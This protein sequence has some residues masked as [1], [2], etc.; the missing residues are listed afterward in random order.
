MNKP[1]CRRALCGIE[2]QCVLYELEDGTTAMV[3]VGAC[4]D[5]EVEFR[6]APASFFKMMVGQPFV[7]ATELKKDTILE[8]Q[9]IIESYEGYEPFPKERLALAREALLR[10]YPE[11]STATVTLRG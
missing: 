8:G 10:D 4:R 6:I 7:P 3:G 5:G 9:H 2:D 11:D 1:L